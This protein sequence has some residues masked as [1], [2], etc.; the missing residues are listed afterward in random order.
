MKSIGQ[1]P[2]TIR[3][4]F[5]ADAATL[6]SLFR[7]S[8]RE[9]AARDYSASQI[10]AWAPDVI[11]VSQFGKRCA[12]KSTWIAEVAGRIAG[13]SDMESDGH[14]DMLYVHPDFQ[15]CGVAR[16]LLRRIEELA[17][18]CGLVRLY[19]EASIT[20]RPAF[21]AMGFSVLVPQI[22]TVRGERMTNYRMEK[23]L[24]PAVTSE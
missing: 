9:I 3:R 17:R 14:V 10:L 5:A 13:F 15:R 19:T 8:V 12:M 6:A 20:A 1:R 21:E 16:A 24:T 7:A 2:I 11:D 18:G 23:K 4:Y 22:V